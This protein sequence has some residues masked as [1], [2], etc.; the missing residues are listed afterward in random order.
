MRYRVA[1]DVAILNNGFMRSDCIFEPGR[2][3]HKTINKMIPFFDT[4]CMM[5]MTGKTLIEAL[6]CGVCKYPS[7][8]GRF[9]SVSGLKF[10]FDSKQPPG[11]RVIKESIVLEKGAFKEDDLYHVAAKG[12]I[13]DGKF[14]D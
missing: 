13:T 11:Q 8:D 9:P 3:T 10:A 4:V 6:E 12:F 2:I 14:F 5:E 1:A 7:Y